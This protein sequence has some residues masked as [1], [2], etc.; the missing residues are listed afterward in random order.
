[1]TTETFPRPI[2]SRDGGTVGEVTG[3]T[4]RCQLEGCTGEQYFVR[5][6][7]GK[8]TWP[9]SKGIIP[10]SDGTWKIG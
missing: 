7:D 5:W 2:I 9:C 8:R 6:P 3:S 4:R 10:E 1:M